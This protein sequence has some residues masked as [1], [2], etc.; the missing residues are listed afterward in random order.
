MGGKYGI[1]L[2]KFRSQLQPHVFVTYFPPIYCIK[3]SEVPAD[4]PLSPISKSRV[5]GRMNLLKSLLRLF[6][7]M[8]DEFW[9]PLICVFPLHTIWFANKSTVSG[10][11]G[12]LGASKMTQ[13]SAEYDCHPDHFLSS[14][15]H[16]W[17]P[18]TQELGIS[19]SLKHWNMLRQA[20]FILSRASFLRNRRWWEQ[21]MPKAYQQLSNVFT[22]PPLSL[23]F[24]HT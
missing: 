23:T 6:R 12:R 8:W 7:A 21:P 14:T 20:C 1:N 11:T 19:G 16:R 18:A 17:P 13:A 4:T 22:S 9:H 24:W 15:K 2:W 10:R 5:C 3:V